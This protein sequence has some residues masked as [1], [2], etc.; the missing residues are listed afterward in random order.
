LTGTSNV[1]W[2]R[3]SCHVWAEGGVAEQKLAAGWRPG[4]GTYPAPPLEDILAG[5]GEADTGGLAPTVAP[6]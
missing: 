4:R 5:A 2:A 6:G 3:N 1:P